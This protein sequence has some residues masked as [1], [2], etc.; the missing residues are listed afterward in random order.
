MTAA[1]SLEL[2]LDS[3]LP[4][5]SSEPLFMLVHGAEKRYQR[6]IRAAPHQA[7]L[8]LGIES[9]IILLNSSQPGR[10]FLVAYGQ[11]NSPFL[12]GFRLAE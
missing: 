3:P 9:P 4:L 11:D 10:E 12:P 2:G 1:A 5:T 7:G 8:L 6:E